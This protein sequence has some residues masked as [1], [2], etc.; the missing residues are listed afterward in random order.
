MLKL[1]RNLFTVNRTALTG[2]SLVTMSLILPGCGG[3]QLKPWHTE[4]LDEEFT[5]DKADEVQTFDDY[6][7]LED[8]LY[9][10]LNDEIYAQTETGP[11]YRLD[12]YSSGSAADPRKQP[13]DWNRSFELKADKARGGVLLIHGMSDSPYSLRTL[14]KAL[15]KRGFWVIGMRMPGHGTAPSGLL[16]L[17]WQDMLAAVRLAM[18]HLAEQYRS[19]YL[20]RV[21]PPRQLSLPGSEC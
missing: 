21:C 20:K 18:I 1:L 11:E 17:T 4:K 3:A 19:R 13:P 12:R 5:E 7:Q 10:Q 9:K 6:L 15:N 2:F 16:D 14:G 8:R